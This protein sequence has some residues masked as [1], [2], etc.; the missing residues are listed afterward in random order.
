MKLGGQ[1]E[2]RGKVGEREETLPKLITSFSP[3]TSPAPRRP[4][5][6]PDRRRPLTRNPKMSRPRWL[7]K[8]MIGSKMPQPCRGGGGRWGV[9][10]GGGV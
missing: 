10:R 8:Q 5:A 2:G 1:E 9:G 4:S 3:P 6:P 7:N